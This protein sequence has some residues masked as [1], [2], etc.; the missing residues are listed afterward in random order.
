MTT[1]ETPPKI[2][3]PCPDYPIKI[4]GLA[5]SDFR[6]RTLQVVET[7]APGFDVSKMEVRDSRNGKY[8][9]ITLKITATGEEQLSQLN[10]ELRKNPQV[11]MLL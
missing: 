9:S 8:Q 2:E 3:F 11:K 6:E 10:T 1:E 7:F 4:V 5:G